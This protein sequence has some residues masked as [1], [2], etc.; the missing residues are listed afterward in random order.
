MLYHGVFPL[1][2]FF[3]FIAVYITNACT[4]YCHTLLSNAKYLCSTDFKKIDL[5]IGSL[6]CKKMLQSIEPKDLNT[7]YR[8]FAYVNRALRKR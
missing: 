3:L 7:K 5:G 2:Y 4:I 6:S 8:V 1:K